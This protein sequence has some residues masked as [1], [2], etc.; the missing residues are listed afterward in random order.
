MTADTCDH[1]SVNTGDHVTADT[2]DHVTDGTGDHVTADTGD[3]VTAG[4]CAQSLQALKPSKKSVI[5]SMMETLEGYVLHLEDKV[6]ERTN[7]LA[8]ANS[9]LQTLLH[10]ILPKPVAGRSLLN[11]IL[12]KPVAGRSLLHQI[13]PKPVTAAADPAKTCRR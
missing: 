5:E 12:P 2:G 4:T 8:T 7:E 11:Q 6:D 1:V 10:Q 3:P 9:Q 13:L